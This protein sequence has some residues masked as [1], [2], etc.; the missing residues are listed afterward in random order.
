MKQTVAAILLSFLIG[1]P[2]AAA[3]PEPAII[4]PLAEKSLLLDIQNVDQIYLVAVGE[5]GH[6]LRSFD[7][8]TWTQSSVPV[9]STL[10]GV[11]FISRKLGWAV[12]HDATIL[13][14]RDGGETWQIQQYLPEKEKPLLD[15]LFKDEENGIAIGAYGMFYRT[16]NG[17]KTWNEQFHDEFLPEEDAQ[18]LNEL[19][20]EDEESY[21][22][23]RASILPHFNRI[24]E[25]GRTLYLA[26]EMG[27]IAKSND[28]GD[29]WEPYNSIYRGSFFDMERT[30]SGNLIVAGLRGNVFRSLR[31]GTPWQHIQTRSTALINDIVLTTDERIFM[32]GNSG[33]LLVS[34]DDGL[35]FQFRPQP[36]GKSL[37]AGTW[38][39][40]TLYA[41]S[42]VGIKTITIAK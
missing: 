15:V 1:Q 22:D 7:G 41:V 5:R 31:N 17:G 42:E 16:T 35:T 32:L 2:F 8:L 11:Y 4:A 13:N 26:G 19:R 27:L 3:N 24:V 36:D 20:M 9:Q 14:T 28:F 30:Q 25:D 37:I 39:R 18:Y 34:E 29:T 10:T 12:G 38:F 33:S 6:I 21:Y 40:D 23:E